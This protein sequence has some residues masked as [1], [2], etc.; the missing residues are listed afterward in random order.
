MNINM[1][2]KKKKDDNFP[3]GSGKTHYTQEPR[4]SM[5]LGTV[6]GRH[7]KI[8]TDERLSL[9]CGCYC[10]CPDTQTYNNA[11]A[12]STGFAIFMEAVTGYC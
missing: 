7:K 8:S 2:L 5:I 1:E 12:T 3:T 6:G 10:N 11:R 4:N 9:G